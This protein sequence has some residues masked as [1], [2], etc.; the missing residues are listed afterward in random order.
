MAVREPPAG[1]ARSQRPSHHDGALAFFKD[2]LEAIA[3]AVVMALVIKHF[4]VEAFKIP[5]SSMFPTL[6]GELNNVG[7]QGDRILV[8]KLAYVLGR[9]QRWD[10]VV[11]R[12]P[13]DL[14]RNFIKRVAGLPGEHLCIS[15]DGDLWVRPAGDRY[16]EQDL[17]IAQKPRDV[18]QA[19]YRAV[20]PPPETRPPAA[21]GSDDPARVVHHT[22]VRIEN[23]W[24]AGAGPPSGWRLENL[25]RFVFTGGTAAELHNVPRILAD[26]VPGRWATAS[27][28][29]ELVRDVRFRLRLHVDAVPAGNTPAP[30]HL[31]LRWSPDAERLAVLQLGSTDSSSEAFVR[32]G[33][34]TLGRASLPV[35]LRPGGTYRLEMEYVDGRLHARVDDR[36]LAVIADKRRFADTRHASGDQR[37]RIEAAGGGLEVLDLR[38]D[39]DLRYQNVWDSNPEARNDG[40]DIPAGHYFMLGDNTTNSSD[41]RRWRM[42]H[43]HLKDGR[44]IL[45]D[46]G[47]SPE[48]VENPKDGRTWKRVTDADGIERTWAEEDEDPLQGSETVSAPFVAR[49]LIVGRAFLVFWPWTPTFPGRLGFLK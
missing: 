31:A 10:I 25:H 16:G 45:H 12:Y 28:A 48:Y 21:G 1:T 18:R 32:R 4:C 40:I 15:D 46:Q 37:L 44:T 20:Y 7:G 8:D 14:A 19:F 13:L 39:R 30:T 22:P 27:N 42:V 2:N 9:P 43:V 11:F 26:S 23:Y 36:E 24:R 35:H 6:H 29:G 49:D 38:I 33:T 34:E 47:N 17:E 5:T 41:S 3:V